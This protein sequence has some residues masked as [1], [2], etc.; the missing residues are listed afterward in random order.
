MTEENLGLFSPEELPETDEKKVKPKVNCL[1]DILIEVM[2]ERGLT[3][4]QIVKATGIAWSTYFGW[5]SGQTATQLADKNLLKLAQYLN[6]SIEYLCFGIGTDDP[7]F[8]EF[9]RKDANEN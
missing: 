9:D 3:D 2:N 1:Q 6:L 8:E 5:V 7:R 4:A